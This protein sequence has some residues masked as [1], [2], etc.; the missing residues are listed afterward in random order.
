[1]FNI[2]ENNVDDVVN[3]GFEYCLFFGFSKS[4]YLL[5]IQSVIRKWNVPLWMVLK[6]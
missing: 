2:Y 1:M 3:E 5:K 4:D 6:P